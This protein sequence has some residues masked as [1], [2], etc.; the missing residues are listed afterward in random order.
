MDTIRLLGRFCL[1][2]RRNDRGLA[3]LFR[4][5]DIESFVDHDFNYCLRILSM[6]S[7]SSTC[8]TH[9]LRSDIEFDLVLDSLQD[10]F[11]C[12][13]GEISAVED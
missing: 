6:Q 11:S 8:G 2:D 3:I 12:D 9:L 5:D 4:T 10:I 13:C 1:L 7:I